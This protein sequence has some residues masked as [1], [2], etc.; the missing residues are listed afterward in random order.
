MLPHPRRPA[1]QPLGIADQHRLPTL[2]THIE[3]GKSFGTHSY[4]AF[5]PPAYYVIAAPLLK[6]SHGHHTRILILRSFGLF[7]LV[8]TVYVFWRF[9]LMVFPTRP[10]VPFALGMTFFLLPGVIVRSVTISYQP[11]A[12]LLAVVCLALFYKTYRAPKG[13]G[14][15]WLLAS[16]AALSL[17]VV[18]HALLAYLAG[19]FAIVALRR[20][21]LERNRHVVLFLVSCAAIPIAIV[22]PWLAFNRI[23]YG[24][25]TANF[26]ARQ[27]QQPL[28][29]PTNRQSTLGDVPDMVSS[30][31]RDS[32]LPNEWTPLTILER[33]VKVTE[34]GLAALLFAVP[35]VVL[36]VRPTAVE[37][38]QV[39]LLGLPF[40][41]SFAFVELT[42]IAANWQ[43]QGRYL[44]GAAGAFLL[45]GYAVFTQVFRSR[46]PALIV[47]GIAMVGA[48]YLWIESLV[49]YL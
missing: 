29:N 8:L 14:D 46:A 34:W 7:L 49:R 18:T 32:F 12:T 5:Q 41:L 28:I 25:L 10:L 37:N 3:L 20:L 1:R 30:N 9:A 35:V 48:G 6:L 11:L 24:S 44:Y 26:V 2:D 13:E 43:S 19:V 45:F 22:G 31:V 42:A 47:L 15:G 23:H 17:A 16:T 27:I 33:P 21:W 36:A 38:D 4:E 39:L 40:L